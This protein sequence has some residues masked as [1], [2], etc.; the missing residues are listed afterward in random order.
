MRSMLTTLGYCKL[1]PLPRMNKVI[2]LY[3]D[4]VDTNSV[5]LDLSMI[6]SCLPALYKAILQKRREGGL[7]INIPLAMTSGNYGQKRRRVKTR[8]TEII[9]AAMETT[10]SKTGRNDSKENTHVENQRVEEV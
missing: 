2:L 8:D 1:S 3:T 10:D 7:G 9:A 6:I 4:I 5:E